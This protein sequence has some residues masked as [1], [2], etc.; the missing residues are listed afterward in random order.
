M[1]TS[2][3][4][5]DGCAAPTSNPKFPRIARRRG[6]TRADTWRRLFLFFTE[7]PV[8]R[9]ID[10]MKP[11]TGLAEHRFV[12]AALIAGHGL[13]R[14]PMLHVHTGPGT[15]EDEVAHATGQSDDCTALRLD[16]CQFRSGRINNRASQVAPCESQISHRN[17]GAPTGTSCGGG[18]SLTRQVR[19]NYG[20]GLSVVFLNSRSIRS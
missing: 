4:R 1:A 16:P 9:S 8:A 3:S 14:Q 19:R 17:D 13:V 7:Q 10:E 11:A 2:N 20:V 18:I 12:G 6:W 5:C 15:F